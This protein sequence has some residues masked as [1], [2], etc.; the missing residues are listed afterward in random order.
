MEVTELQEISVRLYFG[1]G[2][3]IVEPFN[4]G[5]ESQLMED[6]FVEKFTLPVAEAMLTF[7]SFFQVEAKKFIDPVRLA[8]GIS[9]TYRLGRLPASTVRGA[10]VGTVAVA[11]L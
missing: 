9:K 3:L 10:E 7:F 6:M 4:D 11:V 1:V 2:P 5:A 8:F